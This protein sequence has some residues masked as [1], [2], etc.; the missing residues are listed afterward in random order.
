MVAFGYTDL[1]VVFKMFLLTLPA[2]GRRE[3]ARYR[4][5]IP[6][7]AGQRGHFIDK[8]ISQ[9]ILEKDFRPNFDF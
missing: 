7:P 3:C 5:S 6:V 9:G 1:L 4:S 8:L 2:A